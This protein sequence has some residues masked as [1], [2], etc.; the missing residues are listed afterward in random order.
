MKMKMHVMS[1]HLTAVRMAIIN[2]ATKNECWRGC[3]EKGALLHCWGECTLLQPLWRTAW[4]SLRKLNIELPH[5]PAIPLLGISPD[6]TFLEKET[7]TC[8]FTAAL[9]TIAKTWRQPKCPSDR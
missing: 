3:G 9:F 2:K 4:R 7:C 6:K 1:N 5:D 8:L